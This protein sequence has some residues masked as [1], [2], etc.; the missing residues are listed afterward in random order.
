MNPDDER[1][2]RR[3]KAM[4]DGRGVDKAI[5]CSGGVR[6]QL[7][8]VHGTRRKGQVAFVGESK[9]LTLNVSDDLIRNGLTVHGNWHWNL[10]D[11]PQM[12][13][14]IADSKSLIAKLV[15]HEFALAEAE[16]AFKL[17]MSGACGKV[18]LHP[19]A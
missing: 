11:A 10:K 13:R 19:W 12:L 3:I 7:A 5:E 14:T 6:Y 4:T 9:D 18:L 15:T 2:L 8:C 1:G 16:E 17:Q